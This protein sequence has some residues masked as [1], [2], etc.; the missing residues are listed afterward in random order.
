MFSIEQYSNSA[1]YMIVSIHDMM[2]PNMSTYYDDNI[3][4]LS[5]KIKKLREQQQDQ[6]QKAVLPSNTR[7]FSPTVTRKVTTNSRG[8]AMDDFNDEDDS[9]IVFK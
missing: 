3:F 9:D 6:S 1:M 2:Q 4:Y 7:V 5:A 8:V